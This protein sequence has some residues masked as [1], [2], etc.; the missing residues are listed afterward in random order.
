[1]RYRNE[2]YSTPSV[3]QLK[4]KAEKSAARLTKQGSV[5]S[6][7]SIQGRTIARSWWGKAWMNNLQ[8]YA[9]YWNRLAR[10]RSYAINGLVLDLQVGANRIAAVVQ[11]SRT[12]PYEVSVRIDALPDRR[13]EH[14]GKF[15]AER[16]AVLDDLLSG[17]FPADLAQTFTDKKIGLFPSPREIH[18]SCSC[19]DYAD[20]CKHVAAVLCG[21]GA[22]LD[23]QPELFFTMRGVP[24]QRLLRHSVDVRVE[25]MMRS[26]AGK[27]AR[28]LSTKEVDSLFGGLDGE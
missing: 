11:G 26:A 23:E 6:P 21:V 28:A 16:I 1:M 5:L 13:L 20:M 8:S 22:R 12:A 10:G 18:F 17:T 9:D 3:G 4:A 25:G 24:T 7:V 19:P 14:I 15:C 2:Y 27:S